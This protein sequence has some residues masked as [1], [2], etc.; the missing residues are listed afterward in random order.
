M[1]RHLRTG[2][3][4]PRDLA[5][6]TVTLGLGSHRSVGQSSPRTLDSPAA[7]GIEVVGLTKV[8]R[9]TTVVQNVSFRCRPGTITAF[10]GPNGSGKTTTLRMLVGFTRPSSGY[11]TVDGVSFRDLPN[12]G[13]VVGVLLDASA[14]HTGRSVRETLVLV[15]R[16][17]GVPAGEVDAV[18]TAVGLESVH[19]RRVGALSLGMRQRLGLATALLGRPRHLIL[20]EPMNGLDPEGMGWMR[21]MLIDFARG[22]GTVLISSHL[23]REVHAV[24]DHVVVIDRG[25]V[26]GAGPV[27]DIVADQVTHVRSDDDVLLGRALEQAGYDVTT[28]SA[29]GGLVV[30]AVARDVGRVALA[31]GVVLHHLGSDGATGLENYVLANTHGEF[32]TRTAP[33]VVTRRVSG[34]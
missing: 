5:V 3:G 23:L 8:Y 22:G 13:R 11:A 4:S 16:T 32:A 15:G 9:R 2:G 33:E 18:L 25:A 7:C 28:A 34:A 1:G 21:R 6:V 24:A 14:Q 31:A 30:R 10:L 29:E 17:I 26:V 20:D 12:P 27:R 19:R